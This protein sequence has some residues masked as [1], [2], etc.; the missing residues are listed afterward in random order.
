MSRSKGN[1]KIKFSQVIE[2]NIRKTIDKTDIK[3]CGETSPRVLS[4]KC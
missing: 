1:Q 3:C 4:K 2:Y